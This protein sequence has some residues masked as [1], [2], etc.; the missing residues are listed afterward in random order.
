MN[1]TAFEVY[2]QAVAALNLAVDSRRGNGFKHEC[3]VHDDKEPSVNVDYRDGKVLVRC[4]AGCQTADVVAALDLTFDDLFDEEPDK[5]ANKVLAAEYDYHDGAGNYVFSKQRY[6][7]KDFRIAVKDGKG[8]YSWGLP[9]GCAAWLYR[10]PEVR[11]AS[12]DG[13]TVW[14]VEGEKDADAMKRAY[15]VVATTQPHGAGNGKFTEWHARCLYGADV[16]IIADNDDVGKAYALE[17]YE[18]LVANGTEPTV[19]LAKEGKD[20]YDH[21]QAGHALEDFRPLP[22]P[23][24]RVE[25]IVGTELMVK[26]FKPLVFAVDGILPQGVAILAGSP[27]AGKSFITLDWAVGVATGGKTMSEL[28]C[29]AGDVLYIGLE[30][31]E[32]RV[33]DRLNLLC[34]GHVPNLDRIEF[35][36]IDS[37]WVGGQQGMAWM[38]EWA[39]ERP[40]P[41]LI[42]IDTLRKAE[43]D[44]DEARNQYIAEQETMLRYKR[45]ADRY[46]LSV[47]MVHHSNKLAADTVDWLDR[48]SGSKGLTGGADTLLF[49]DYKRGER[50]GLLRIEGRDVIADDVPI[51]KPRHR[52]F[53]LVSAAPDSLA[54]ETWATTVDLEDG[55][56][57]SRRETA[58]ITTL[59]SGP[60]NGATLRAAFPGADIRPGLDLLMRAGL[61]VAQGDTY[62][63]RTGEDG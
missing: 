7:P 12:Q 62:R 2:E 52:P 46:N 4:H 63:L 38:A 41:R 5:K 59:A 22:K 10:A 31:S 24:L 60:A 29:K 56:V 50:E 57:L 37:G 15:G 21:I 42:I 11:Q 19:W 3:P 49:V 53:W 45:F 51:Y 27:K 58:L 20:A 35:Q 16:R 23:Q 18:M 8:G 54:E 9:R 36:T 61:L 43:P 55:P 33:K 44:L 30:D 1:I 47:V 34:E 40:D 32:R 13:E 28:E 17:V 48:F 25:G 6:F 39:E 14:L 26:E